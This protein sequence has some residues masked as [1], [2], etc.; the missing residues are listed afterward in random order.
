MGQRRYLTESEIAKLLEACKLTSYP[1]RNKS[2]VLLA[3][4]HGLR[5]SELCSLQWKDL[6]EGRTRIHVHRVKK[7]NSYDHHL[8]EDEIRALGF[9]EKERAR[10]FPWIKESEDKAY[11]FIS[12]R[13]DAMTPKGFAQL[14][15]MLGRKAGLPMKVFPHMLR[16]ACGYYL[17]NKGADARLI[18]DYLGHRSLNQIINYTRVNHE[19]FKDL[20]S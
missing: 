16:H 12:K 13:N 11:I 14:M 20:F 4:R 18:Q 17:A 5:A 2:M 3:F 7:G 15:E 1:H 9:W 19:R 8:K 10:K 6:F